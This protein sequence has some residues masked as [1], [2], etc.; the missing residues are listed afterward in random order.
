MRFSERF[1]PGTLSEVVG[2]PVTALLERFVTRPKEQAFACEGPPGCGKTSAA[3]ALAHDLGCSDFGGLYVEKASDLNV[4]RCR[5]LFDQTLRLIPMYGSRW[6]MLIIE[7]FEYVV[8]DAVK[9]YLKVALENLPPHTIVVATSNDASKIEKALR[10]RFTWLQFSGG[11]LF[12]RYAR[13]YIT[14]IWE[15]EFPHIDLPREWT[16]WGWDDGEFSMRLAWTQ[17]ENWAMM[18]EEVVV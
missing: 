12:A 5:Q 4:D 9:R 14:R 1:R 15:R 17:L 6:K 18:V 3:Y 2:Q 13:E 10:Q 11:P 7:E 16:N 8:S